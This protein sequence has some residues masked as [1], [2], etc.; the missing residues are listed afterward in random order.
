MRVASLAAAAAVAGAWRHGAPASLY[1]LFE[2][3]ANATS[4]QLNY[5]NEYPTNGGALTKAGYMP[6]QTGPARDNWVCAFYPGIL[7]KLAN[8]SL[9]NGDA[10]GAAWWLQ[11]GNAYSAHLK[12]NENNTGTHDV[13]ACS[14]RRRVRCVSPGP[15]GS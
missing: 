13:G 7:W 9:A 14:G 5:A 2:T 3:Q 6:W 10:S 15:R 8:R 12:D 11:Q 1:A 4:A